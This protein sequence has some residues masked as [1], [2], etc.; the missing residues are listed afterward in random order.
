MNL[1]TEM[2]RVI[3]NLLSVV[4]LILCAGCSSVKPAQPV[5]VITPS[6]QEQ[7]NT[8][9]TNLMTKFVNGWFKKAPPPDL[10][11]TDVNGGVYYTT[12]IFL[13][14]APLCFK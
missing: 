10:G 5:A 13:M 7:T 1:W 2:K 12:E 3:V 8:T 4:C 6:F 14:V 9:H 11:E